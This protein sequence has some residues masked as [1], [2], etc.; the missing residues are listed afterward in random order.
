[1]RAHSHIV[2]CG[3]TQTVFIHSTQKTLN[4]TD[5]WQGKMVHGLSKNGCAKKRYGK[6]RTDHTELWEN[7]Q[8]EE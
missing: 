6:G 5:L 2:L 7:R 3:T 4:F 8:G 1:M